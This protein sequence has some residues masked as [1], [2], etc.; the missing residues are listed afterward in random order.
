[1]F[2]STA[3][4][5]RSGARG[6]V[7]PPHRG[8]PP[9]EP[10]RRRWSRRPCGAGGRACSSDHSNPSPRPGR[11]RDAAM[12][13]GTCGGS[14]PAGVEGVPGRAVNPAR[15]RRAG[16]HARVRLPTTATAALALLLALSGGCSTLAYLAEQ[17][18]GQLHILATRRRITEVLGDPAGLA[19]RQ[20]A[21][22]AGGA[23][24]ASSACG[25]WGCAAATPTRATSTPATSRSRGACTLRIPTD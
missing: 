16:Y 19:R 5:C 1:M 2:F 11:Y 9:E 25:S 7:Q 10:P 23:G 21:A 8:E 15:H 6:R 22:A 17:G 12:V 18:R 14:I 3:T 4:P 24:R 20:G 13:D